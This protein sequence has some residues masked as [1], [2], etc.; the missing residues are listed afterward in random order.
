MRAK[1]ISR[2]PWDIWN[3]QGGPKYP[4]EKLIQF[5]CRNYAIDERMKT[6]ALDLGCGSGVH[7]VFL[8]SEG[9]QVT[10]TDR[11]AIG[12][13]NTRRKLAARGLAAE[14]RVEGA[15]LLNYPSH[16]FDLIVSVGLYDSSGPDVARASVARVKQ[17]LRPGGRGF[18]LFASD[19]DFQV[20]GEN[21]YGLYGY[22]RSE[23]EDLF[24]PGFTE[25]F[26]DRYITT[27]ESERIEQNDWLVTLR[28]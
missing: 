21:P 8:A 14:L 12:V 19:R 26:F 6:R 2:E 9:F 24:E 3:E 25:V 23:V 28:K 17:V 22:S 4:H 16:S 13:E 27:Y 18:F 15:D 7:V 5:C 11:S 10:G 20:Q 1:G